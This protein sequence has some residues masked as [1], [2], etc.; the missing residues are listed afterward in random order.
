MQLNEQAYVVENDKLIYDGKRLIDADNVSVTVPTA[1]VGVLK[2]GQIIDFTDGEY[3]PHA[4]SGVASAIVAESTDYA[5]DDT[6]VT[7]AVYTSG[8]FRA[9]ACVSD[10][11][12]VA[13]DLENLRSKG[14]YLK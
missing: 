8:N 10:V 4:A 3:V 13:A 6:T 11:D 1:S 5:A 7:V 9:S 12:L 2:R 14:I